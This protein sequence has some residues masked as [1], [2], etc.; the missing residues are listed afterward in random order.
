MDGVT[1]TGYRASLCPFVNRS[2]SGSQRVQPS[3]RQHCSQGSNPLSLPHQLC[4]DQA[5]DATGHPAQKGRAGLCSN[6]FLDKS[7]SCQSCCGPW[8]LVRALLQCSKSEDICQST[9]QVH[10]TP[11][12]SWAVL[13]KCIKARGKSKMLSLTPP[14][15]V[16][17]AVLRM[18]AFSHLCP[19][20]AFPS[21]TDS[22]LMCM[23]IPE[24]SACRGQE[25]A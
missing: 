5:T 1:W 8:C 12:T 11:N 15:P 4:H 23:G 22:Y 2:L 6:N 21:K 3:Q 10:E 25:G 18:L 7:T 24:P 17:R 13:E 9:M 14:P 16:L 19:A 20:R